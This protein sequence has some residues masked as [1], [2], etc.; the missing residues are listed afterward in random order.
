MKMVESFHNKGHH[1]YVDNFYSSLALFTS[2]SAVGIGA[3]GTLRCNRKGTP[4]EIKKPHTKL[5]KGDLLTCVSGGMRFLKWKDKREV[6]ILT[7]IHDDSLISKRRRTRSVPG[8]FEDI[9]K[10]QAVEQ[11]NRYMGGVDKM[12]QYLSYYG[13]TRRTCKWWKKAFFSLMDTAMVNAYILYSKSHQSSKKLSHMQFRIQLAKDLLCEASHV[14]MSPSNEVLL[15]QS[16]QSLL[17]PSSRLTERHFLGKIP[18]RQNGAPGQRDCVV[19]SGRKGRGR[20][21]TTYFCKQCGV[22]LCV[23]PCFELYHTKV[24]PIRHLGREL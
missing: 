22:G 4:N 8:G 7:T 20:K 10:P 1:L 12:D 16:S 9:S 2:L 24:D 17:P 5:S 14:V 3:C 19:C 21:T 23:V 15:S 6:T 18:P 11:Y 13:F